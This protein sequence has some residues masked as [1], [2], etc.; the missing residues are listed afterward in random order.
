L[1]P[2]VTKSVVVRR[3][4]D[5]AAVLNRLAMAQIVII[6]VLESL[7]RLESLYGERDMKSWTLK[8]VMMMVAVATLTACPGG[9]GKSAASTPGSATGACTI[10]PNGQCVG[11]TAF[12]GSGQWS[13]YLTVAPAQTALY[14]TFLIE[15]GLCYGYRC[16][17]V[18]QWVG[19]SMNLRHNR[20]RMVITPYESIGWSRNRLSRRG[21]AFMQNNG[22]G[23]QV[24][25]QH[26]PMQIQI[27]PPPPAPGV[28]QLSSIFVNQYGNMITTTLYYRGVV[29][30]TGQLQG[31]R[32]L[33]N[34]HQQTPLGQKPAVLPYQ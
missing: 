4:P 15:N 19:V 21:Q 30:A 10:G 7:K 17:A 20:A 22:T 24:V 33:Y 27:Y 11:G 3:F 31:Q 9:K 16:N 12:T 34:T 13:G 23:F 25:A 18:T 28:I 26:P 8:V 1:S 29:I 5:S 32:E 6:A 14:R 2:A